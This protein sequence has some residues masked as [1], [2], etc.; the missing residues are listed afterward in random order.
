MCTGTQTEQSDDQPGNQPAMAVL[1]RPPAADHQPEAVPE[2]QQQTA[3]RQ[4]QQCGHEGDTVA[5]A[6][7]PETVLMGRKSSRRPKEKPRT[8][9]GFP[10]FY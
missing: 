4:R 10:G 5:G 9:R 3:Q 1:Q 7:R 2:Q 6:A 8:G